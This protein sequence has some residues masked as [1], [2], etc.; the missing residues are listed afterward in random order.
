MNCVSCHEMLLRDKEP[1]RCENGAGCLV[2]ALGE[3]EAVVL[4]T[5]ALLR[6]LDGLVSAADV[7]RM[8]RAFFR[9]QGQRRML[10]L[11]AYTEETMMEVFFKDHDT[12]CD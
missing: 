6:R 11:L 8:R 4:E 7:L 12:A 10:E 2:P 3:E 1:P 5:H 9:G